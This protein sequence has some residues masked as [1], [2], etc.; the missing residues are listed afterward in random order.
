MGIL[1]PIA[2]SGVWDLSGWN[3]SIERGRNKEHRMNLKRIS[4][5][6]VAGLVAAGG[7]L[8]IAPATVAQSANRIAS[9]Q[10]QN[11]DGFYRIEAI[12]RNGVVSEPIAVWRSGGDREWEVSRNGQRCQDVA[13]RLNSVLQENGGTLRGLYLTLGRVNGNLV[14][15]T[16][17]ETTLGCN[18]R[19]LLFAFEGDNRA[20]PARVLAKVLGLDVTIDIMTFGNFLQD[21]SPLPMQVL[22]G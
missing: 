3:E 9:F 6:V 4:R 22:T 8:G 1:K 19:N 10:C 18:P 5:W 20:E 11:A 21:F 16:V 14:V 13:E 15:C 2:A 12:A 7:T 17:N